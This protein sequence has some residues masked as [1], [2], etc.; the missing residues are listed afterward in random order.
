MTPDEFAA[1][2][3]ALTTQASDEGLSDEAMIAALESL[4]AAIRESLT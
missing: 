2:L 3:E 4:A 1:H